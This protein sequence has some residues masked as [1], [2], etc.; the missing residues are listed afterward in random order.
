MA[1]IPMPVGTNLADN[2][3]TRIIAA[4]SIT[5]AF[6][7]IA[8]TLRFI[9]RR[10][11]GTM[12]WWD[13]Y[14]TLPAMV[15]TTIQCFITDIWL[16]QHGFGKHIW[17][18]SLGP[19]DATVVFLK[20]LII[21]E[22]TFAMTIVF[23]KFSLLCFYWRLFKISGWVRY[24]IY[25]IGA[26]V[27][28]WGIAVI[29]VIC[30]QCI[31]LK[32]FWDHNAEATCAVDAYKFFYGNSIPNILTDCAILI[33]PIQSVQALKMNWVQKLS[34]YSIFTLGAAVIG[35][36][37]TRLISLVGLDW[38]SP[39]LTWNGRNPQIWTCLEM[40]IAI[41]CSC[42]PSLRPILLFIKGSPKSQISQASAGVN[43]S[44]VPP[45][46]IAKTNTFTITTRVDNYQASEDKHRLFY[47]MEDNQTRP[48][49][50]GTEL[51]EWNNKNFKA[52]DT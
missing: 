38:V 32:G 50:N 26:T 40:N 43:S 13:D 47:Q 20:S 46:S 23:V 31:P 25:V 45:W 21:G 42:L 30:F 19:V 52:I 11:S 3:Q 29:L 5:W 33:L 34:L 37:I 24:A 2:D 9:A 51:A 27:I 17:A 14:F 6:A 44:G 8:V 1:E 15:F 41:T 22:I 35:I 28:S 10:L 4:V 18:N 48:I 39:D 49:S 16:M 12:L 7:L 36:S